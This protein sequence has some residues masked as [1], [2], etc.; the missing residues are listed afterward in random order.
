MATTYSNGQQIIVNYGSQP[1][2]AGTTV[3]NGQD[4]ILREAVP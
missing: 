3:V 2:R 4:A 1:F